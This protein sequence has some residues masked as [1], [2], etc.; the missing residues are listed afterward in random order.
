MIDPTVAS[1]NP[2]S[3]RHNLLE[4]IKLIMTINKSK[5]E[6][7]QY[8]FNSEVQ[9]YQHYNLVKEELTSSQSKITGQFKFTYSPLGKSFLKTNK[10]N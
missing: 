4:R 9:K 1:D 2:L 7:L 8:D 3:L 10:N 5:D 6:K